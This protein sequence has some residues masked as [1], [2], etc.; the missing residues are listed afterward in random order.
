MNETSRKK[1]A[2]EG[3]G[4]TASRRC[5]KTHQNTT[6]S[7]SRAW[8]NVRVRRGAAKQVYLNIVLQKKIV[9]FLSVLYFLIKSNTSVA[10]KRRRITGRR[11]FFASALALS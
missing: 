11:L 8:S 1:R 6:H 7:P 4:E 3:E 2:E 10:Q 9:F 5:P